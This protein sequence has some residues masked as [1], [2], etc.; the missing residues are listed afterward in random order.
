MRESA[1]DL[2]YASMREAIVSLELPPGSMIDKDA[3]CERFGVSRSPVSEALARLRANGLVEILPQRGTR[4]AR[5]RMTDMRQAMFV[6]RALEME[7]V[8]VL[9]GVISEDTISKLSMNLQ[10]QAIAVSNQSPGEFFDLDFAFHTLLINELGFP[11]VSETIETARINLQRAAL[12]FNS[13]VSLSDS[14]DEHEVILKA[15]VERNPVA[16]A[17]AMERHLN[18]AL[19][20]IA[21]HSDDVVTK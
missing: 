12:L 5:I 8:R 11:R 7:T 16:A 3:I 10:Y 9:A 4:V 6:R 18:K 15:L 13:R 2:V 17:A 19:E 1:T 21:S 20:R 14:I